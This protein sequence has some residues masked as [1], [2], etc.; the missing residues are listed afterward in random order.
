MNKEPLD[1]PESGIYTGNVFHRRSVPKVHQFNYRIYLFWVKLKELDILTETV[2][3]FSQNK[4]GISVVNFKREDYL[5]DA[6]IPLETAIL[7]KMNT[8]SE[9]RVS[10]D[11]YMLGQIRTFGLYFSPVNFFYLRNA[12]G[13]YTHMLAEVSNTPWNERH[14]YLVDLD[15]QSDCD[16]AFYVSPF[17]PMDMQYKWQVQQPAENIKLNLSCYKQTKHFEAA[18]NMQ[19]QPLTSA[20]LRKSLLSIPSMTV[21]TVAGIY[22]QAIKLFLKRVPIYTHP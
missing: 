7:K 5:G 14:Y 18:I 17:N 6:K 21:K 11:V 4:S 13:K 8:L 22:W 16:K 19:K 1:M 3:G 15:K 12:H 9:V 10:G 20:T 2:S